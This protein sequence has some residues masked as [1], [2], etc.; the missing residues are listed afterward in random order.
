MEPSW[1]S[2]IQHSRVSFDVNWVFESINKSVFGNKPINQSNCRLRP[3]MKESTG[4]SLK[5][6]TA[7][8]RN[9]SCCTSQVMCSTC[10]YRMYR[11]TMKPIPINHYNPPGVY[12]GD[13]LN[14]N[15]CRYPKNNKNC[16]KKD[17]S[18]W[19]HYIWWHSMARTHQCK[20]G[21]PGR[22][23]S[24]RAGWVLRA[25]LGSLGPAIPAEFNTSYLL[26]FSQSVGYQHLRSI[27]IL[28]S[29]ITTLSLK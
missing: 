26:L 14:R 27:C 12:I 8:T 9:P 20:L 4:W 13:V 2:K 22:E 25:G 19:K 3:R 10:T 18:I 5:M 6:S 28:Y 7:K 16:K 29:L 23:S 24:V 1:K 15:S 21:G 11:S 17:W